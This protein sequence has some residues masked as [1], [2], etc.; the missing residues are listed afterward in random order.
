MIFPD[1]ED[2]KLHNGEIIEC[3]WDAKQEAWTYMR[4]RRDKKTPNAWHVYEKVLQSIKDNITPSN[5]VGIIQEATRDNIIYA[6]HS[7]PMYAAHSKPNDKGSAPS[8]QL[9]VNGKPR[10]EGIAHGPQPNIGSA[11]STQ[12]DVNGSAPG[13]KPSDQCT[14]LST[15]PKGSASGSAD[16][17]K[18]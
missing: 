17:V 11:P 3:S 12:L 6:T 14:A 4:D 7:K 13:S 15:Q 5:L 18:Q 2:A 10:D 1:K 16:V 8:T 9:D